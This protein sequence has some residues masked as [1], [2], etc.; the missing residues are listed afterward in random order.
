VVPLPEAEPLLVGTRP[1]FDPSGGLGVP[2]HITLQHPF[3][4]AG[5]LDVAA[6]ARLDGAAA[7]FAPFW[8]DL[9]EVRTDNRLLYVG[10]ADEGPLRALGAALRAPWG[11]VPY[12]GR[13]G[14]DPVPHLSLA[15]GDAWARTAE[16]LAPE[17]SAVAA[18]WLPLRARA[19]A[20]EVWRRGESGWARIHRAPL[21][22]V[23]AR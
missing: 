14:P 5:E 15:Y 4:R 19:E 10:A 23:R 7:A 2:A 8:I 3:L 1:L 13:F 18:R 12:E 20:V 11:L 16:A 22:P 6:R 17:I 9:V 21:G